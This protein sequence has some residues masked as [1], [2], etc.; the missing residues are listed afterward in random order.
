MSGGFW[1]IPDET[2]MSRS[3]AVILKEQAAALRAATKGEL[4]GV[5]GNAPAVSGQVGTRL[6]IIVPSLNNYVYQ[7]LIVR[8]PLL[9]IWPASI[10]SNVTN[11]KI[12]VKNEE[13]FNEALRKILSSTEMQQ[14]IGALRAQVRQ[15][16]SA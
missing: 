5:V 15:A 13:Q 1:V 4:N 2:K 10:E 8:Y 6:S 9:T 12:D 3:P 14:V 11:E 7:V 16:P